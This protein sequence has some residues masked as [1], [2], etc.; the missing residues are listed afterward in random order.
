MGS[1][2]EATC[3]SVLHHCVWADLQSMCLSSLFLLV[4]MTES[5]LNSPLRPP[6]FPALSGS[7]SILLE[8][9]R[10]IHVN[11]HTHTH[12]GKVKVILWLMHV[13]RYHLD[14][15]NSG[16]ACFHLTL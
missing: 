6:P 14:T 8:S 11:E 4:V 15:N 12:T 16:D 1:T 5:G 9:K 10:K 2:P 13:R 3:Y 7:E